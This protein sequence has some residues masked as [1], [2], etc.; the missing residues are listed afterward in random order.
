M[1]APDAAPQPD[2][3]GR[4]RVGPAGLTLPHAKAL[5]DA[6][7]PACGSKIEW[8]ANFD[9]DATTYSGSACCGYTFRM[10]PATVNVSAYRNE[11]TA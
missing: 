7:C 4:Y 9:A 1:S 10:A 3:N 6:A 11:E 2:A 5:Y 8:E